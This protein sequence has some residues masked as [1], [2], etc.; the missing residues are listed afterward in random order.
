MKMNQQEK[1]QLHSQKYIEF[2]KHKKKMNAKLERDREKKIR[3]AIEFR[4]KHSIAFRLSE[5]TASK[6]ELNFC[7]KIVDKLEK[8]RTNI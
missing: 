1:Q 6:E 7:N 3:D 8:F 5:N 4:N 2:I